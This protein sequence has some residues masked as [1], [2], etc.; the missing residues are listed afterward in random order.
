MFWNF[1]MKDISAAKD[2]WDKT[3]DLINEGKIVQ[4]IKYQKNGKEKR[5]TYFPGSTF[6]GVAHVRPH[7]KDSNDVAELPVADL[8]TGE[9]AYTKQCFWLNSE[10]IQNAI[11]NDKDQY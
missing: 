6:N 8:L 3:I 7:G 10:Y 11:E 9:K 2:V 5:L 1:P 4:E